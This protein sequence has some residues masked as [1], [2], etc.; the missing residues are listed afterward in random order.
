[1][2]KIWDLIEKLKTPIHRLLL[3]GKTENTISTALF[4]VNC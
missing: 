4:T 2:G 3:M 1:M